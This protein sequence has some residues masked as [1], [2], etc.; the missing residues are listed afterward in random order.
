METC[1]AF[2]LCAGPR[3]FIIEKNGPLLQRGLVGVILHAN[4]PERVLIT[5]ASM[6][7]LAIP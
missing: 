7:Y 1:G 5:I 3:L 6:H 2:F 4:S